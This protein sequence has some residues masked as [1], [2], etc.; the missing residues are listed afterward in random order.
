MADLY[1]L[2]VRLHDPWCAHDNAPVA[3]ACVVRA[4]LE[5]NEVNAVVAGVYFSASTVGKV[6]SLSSA[7]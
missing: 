1:K 4:G 3:R 5:S 6:W 7:R 2:L